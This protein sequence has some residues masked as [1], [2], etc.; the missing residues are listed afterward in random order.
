MCHPS[1]PSG[2][3]SYIGTIGL[4]IISEY[5][6]QRF[7]TRQEYARGEEQFLATRVQELAVSQPFA[8]VTGGASLWSAWE[9]LASTGCKLVS[10]LRTNDTVLGVLTES[11]MLELLRGRLDRRLADEK[12]C[13]DG[14][15]TPR[16]VSVNEGDSC[17]FAFQKMA[18]HRVTGLAVLDSDTGSVIDCVSLRDLRGLGLQPHQP[19]DSGP[20]VTGFWRLWEP[21]SALKAALRQALPQE[22]PRSILSLPTQASLADTLQTFHRHHVHRVFLCDAHQRPVRVVT[23]SDVLRGVM[24]L[25]L[26]SLVASRPPSHADLIQS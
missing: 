24:D 17:G 20:R 2:D 12:R 26:Q 7:P 8:V 15:S 6:L 10:V 9:L 1:P 4:P 21:V 3:R 13:E 25:L 14:M 22:H 16:V 5:I 18:T 19:P 11:S 23:S